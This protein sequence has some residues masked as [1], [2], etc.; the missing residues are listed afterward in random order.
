MDLLI[1]LYKSLKESLKK[2]LKTNQSALHRLRTAY[3]HTKRTLWTSTQSH[4][5]I[6]SLFEGINFN[7]TITRACFEYLNMDYFRTS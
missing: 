5:E 7:S 4:I 6:N 2:N 1:I 3:E